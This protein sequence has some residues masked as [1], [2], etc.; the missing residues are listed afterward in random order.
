M[1][2][3]REVLLHHHYAYRTETSYCQ[4]I[5]CFI[6]FFG[7]KT[8]PKKLDTYHVERLLSSLATQDKVSASTQRQALNAL[9][10]LHREVI[11]MPLDGKIAHARAK[12]QPHPPTVLTQEGIGM[13]RLG[14][15][16]FTTWPLLIPLILSSTP[17]STRLTPLLIIATSLL[18]L[19]P[20]SVTVGLPFCSH[21]YPCCTLF[22]KQ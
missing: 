4:W 22:V 17:C 12:R 9:V 7:R 19:F 20:T 16:P 18:N 2:Q 14:L 8:H 21:K 6:Y 13:F 11:E 5:L 3:V 1:D 15:F 10:F